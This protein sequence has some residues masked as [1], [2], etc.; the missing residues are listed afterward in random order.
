MQAAYEKAQAVK[1]AH[2]VELM[3]KANVVG[4]GVGFRQRGGARTNEV[5]VVVMVRQKVARAQLSPADVIPTEIEGV[6]VDVQEVG[7][8][9]AHG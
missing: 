6:P 3:G 9:V 2:E 7:E 1:R 5:T 8:I 4:V